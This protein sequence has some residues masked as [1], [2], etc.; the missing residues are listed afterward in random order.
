MLAPIRFVVT[1]TGAAGGRIVLAQTG[2]PGTETGNTFALVSTAS[3]GSGA[4]FAAALRSA[5]AGTPA[6]RA[7]REAQVVKKLAEKKTE[8]LVAL[9]KENAEADEP[10]TRE[11]LESDADKQAEEQ[12]ES[13][14]R[15]TGKF[16]MLTQCNDALTRLLEQASKA[17]KDV[18][19]AYSAFVAAM[20]NPAFPLM[21]CRAKKIT[22][23]YKSV[24]T[25]LDDGNTITTT[26]ADRFSYDGDYVDLVAENLEYLWGIPELCIPMPVIYTNDPNTPCFHFFDLEKAKKAVGVYTAWDE[27][28]SRLSDE[29]AAAF[30]GFVW[31]IFDA[32]NRGR[33][34]LY[35]L[36]KGYS[37]KSAVVNAIAAALGSDL[38]AALSKDSLSN[39]FA[40]SKV[41]DRRFVTI[42]DNKNPNLIRS[43][44][45]HSMLGGDLADVEYKGRDPF[46]ARL[47]CKVFVASNVPLQIDVKAR[48]EYTRVLPIHPDDSAETLVA[49]RLVALNPDG[50]PKLT[51]NG[52]LI[53][54]GDPEWESQLIAQ[55]PAFL[56]SCFS[57]YQQVCPRGMEIIVPEK[58][59]EILATFDDD[60]AA[61]L[62]EILE[63]RFEITKDSSDFM[64]RVDMQRAFTEAIR[65]D[66]TYREA[67]LSFSEW[68]EFLR[69][70]Y[71]LESTRPRA[72]GQAWGYEGIRRKDSATL[73]SDD[74][75]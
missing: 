70:R 67:K 5:L 13:I 33:Q 47:M 55:F 44:A 30:K 74:N 39:Q 56:A 43:Q 48:N 29:E 11:A 4:G 8:L 57:V 40:F 16:T 3:Q 60:R 14:E 52:N 35:I 32:K 72:R 28:T 75:F 12:R 69:R 66:D 31:A 34:C 65:D 10:L 1:G 54:L 61:L 9:E 18:E 58:S 19:S 42:G 49:R 37:G 62:E 2:E 63:T 51:A 68:K 46:P 45:M 25:K 59:A 7:W 6:K 23:W 41:W 26:Y 64:L 21:L 73:L 50:T 53:P 38:H 71:S 24:T 15:E 22:C 27:F 17:V 36:D 20:S